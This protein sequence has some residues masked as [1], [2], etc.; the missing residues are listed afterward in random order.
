MHK[1]GFFRTAA[2]VPKLKLA[3]CQYNIN[4]IIALA[5]KAWEA[6]VEVLLFPELG[7]T[8]YTCGDLF[9]QRELQNEAVAALDQ[10]CQW[11]Q[12]KKLLLVVGLPLVV[13]GSLYNCA[14]TINDGKILGVVPKT[15]IPNYQEFY[16][17]RWFASA[18]SLL[19]TEIKLCSQVVPIGTDLLF[20]HAKH[21]ELV[22]GI[23]ICEDLWVPISPGSFHALAGATV[24]L[25]PSAS[26]EV[27][28][29][30]DYRRELIR[31]QS[32]RG[33]VAYL[34]TSAGFGESTSDLVFG[35]NA[36]ICERGILLKELP[37]FNLGNELL[38]A[39]ID[40]ESLIHDR[41]MMHG[42]GDSFDL[43]KGHHYRT[44]TFETPGTDNFERDVNPWPF[45]PGDL[46]R[47]SERCEEIFNIQTI[48]LATRLAHIGNAPMVVGISGGLDST[49]ALLVC[50]SVCDR[51]NI[52]RTKIHAVTMPGFGTTDRT[53]ENAV[54]LINGLGAT[55]HEIS[56][57]AA[58]QAHFKD[59]GHP[60]DLHNVTYENSQARERTQILMDLANKLG[61]IV[62]GTGDLS[63]LAL[64]WA[65]Y[66][67]DH[68]SMYSVNASVPKTLIRYLV[69]WVADHSPEKAIQEILYDVLDTP[70]SPELLPPDAEG[71]IAQKT[72]ETVGPYELH[73]FFMYQMVRHGFSPEKVYYLACRA[74]DGVYEKAVILKWLKNFY[75][76]FFSQQFKRNC[77]PDGPKV[78]TVSFSPRGD[79]RMPSDAKATQWLK[80]LDAI[81]PIS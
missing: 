68:M 3:D 12:G 35:G 58:C 41:Q 18:K 63:E 55:F 73:D 8:G 2:A 24:I 44:I 56:I 33:N 45:V 10:L 62:I 7:I 71:K 39:D 75:Q 6:G 16:E 4:E 1:Y 20:Q 43:L 15:Y 38:I 79:W 21:E 31:S 69:E 29:K 59:I 48:G 32:G 54:A 37:K 70:V 34:Y 17:K 78:G 80:S 47:R 11:S 26:N 60:P 25:N 61:G 72:E 53:Y 51:F 77:L 19:Q 46:N 74:F 66:N 28:G 65:T 57:V 9:F 27:V 81:K 36:I 22:V 76:R 30:S 23:E 5:A 67:G 52:P 40:V 49:M 13:G 64:G 42:F 14:A 50:V